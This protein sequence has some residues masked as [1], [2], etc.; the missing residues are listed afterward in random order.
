[1]RSVFHTLVSCCSGVS[2][3]EKIAAYCRP[4][5]RNSQVVVGGVV[6][7]VPVA[8]VSGGVRGTGLELQYAV[9]LAQSPADWR[10]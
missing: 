9:G 2:S 4:L 1:M 3:L 7:G 8:A 5:H 10:R 6:R